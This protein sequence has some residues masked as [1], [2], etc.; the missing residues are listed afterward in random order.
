MVAAVAVANVSPHR[1]AW[2]MQEHKTR[3]KTKRPLV[4][5]LSPCLQTLT[6]ILLSVREDGPLLLNSRGKPWT[7]N[8]IRCR[9]K[10][11][12]EKLGLPEGT[13][14]YAYRHT[15]TTNAVLNGVDLATV[16]TMMGHRDLR[17][18]MEHYAHLEKQPEHLRQAAA[19]AMKRRGA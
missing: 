1:D 18:L 9:M 17:M 8:A 11:L 15:W 5:Q 16:A 6:R 2:G 12:Q 3:K 13:V 19:K 14:A 10:A 7:S 4:V